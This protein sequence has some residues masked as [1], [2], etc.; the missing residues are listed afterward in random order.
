MQFY[1]CRDGKIMWPLESCSGL[2]LRYLSS[3]SDLD[4]A[5]L[6][7]ICY[8]FLLQTRYYLQS[9]QATGGHGASNC[10]PVELPWQAW[11]EPWQPGTWE[12]FLPCVSCVNIAPRL[13]AAPEII[14]WG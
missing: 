8:F 1:T 6:G 9:G 2:S 14:T 5:S 4:L 11:V 7:A 10:Q 12:A 13:Q 3:L